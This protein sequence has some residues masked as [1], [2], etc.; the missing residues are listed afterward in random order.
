MKI[1][2][3]KN[4][5][6]QLFSII[7]FRLRLFIQTKNFDMLYCT[8][9]G[10]Q[11]TDT[12]KFCTGCGI[13]LI[14]FDAAKV[15]SPEIV[16]D[17]KPKKSKVW[18]Y[19][20]SASLLCIIAA[21]YFLF[22]RSP[23]KM[24][25]QQKPDSFYESQLTSKT[26]IGTVSGTVATKPFTLK[27]ESIT[28]DK[29]TG[30]NITGNSKRPVKGSFIKAIEQYDLNGDQKN[31]VPNH[32]FLIKINEPG[33]EEWDGEFNLRIEISDW[34]NRGNGTWRAYNGRLNRIIEFK[35]N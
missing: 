31:L 19:V 13:S 24:G 20:I 30:Y 16:I 34:F 11:N 2:K 4:F 15:P 18:V 9:C 17:N 32:V 6:L 12:A 25:S 3:R 33:N 23:S 29:I 10:K 26:Y 7:F 22:F 5:I 1:E 21:S 14:H 28:D 35:G 27:F 8:K